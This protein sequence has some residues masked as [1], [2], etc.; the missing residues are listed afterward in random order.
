MKGIINVNVIV[1]KT[2]KIP[3]I[4]SKNLKSWM[5]MSYLTLSINF[6]ENVNES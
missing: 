1:D 3:N 5:Q 2:C 6:K 4:K